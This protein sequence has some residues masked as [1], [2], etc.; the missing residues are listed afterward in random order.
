MKL[1][2]PRNTNILIYIN[3]VLLPREEA[4]VSVFDSAV[5][6]GDAVW[7]GLRVYKGRIAALNDHLIRLQNSAKALLHLNLYLRRTISAKPYSSL[8]KLTA[9]GMKLILD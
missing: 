3:G 4:K 9:C 2:D 1:P 8:S 5:Q 6:G 7:E